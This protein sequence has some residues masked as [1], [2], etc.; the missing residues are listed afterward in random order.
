[1]GR[2]FC[3]VHHIS[4]LSEVGERRAVNPIT[5]L[6]PVCP[7]CHAMIHRQRPALTPDQVRVILKKAD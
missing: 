4:P 1:M 7:N 2:N 3:H 5:D 6:I